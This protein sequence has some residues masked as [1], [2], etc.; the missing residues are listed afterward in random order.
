M[1]VQNTNIN[2]NNRAFGMF[3]I[4]NLRLYLSTPDLSPRFDARALLPHNCFL[5]FF[6][7]TALSSG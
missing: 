3:I 5:F 6:P 2:D 4:H 7:R 1:T